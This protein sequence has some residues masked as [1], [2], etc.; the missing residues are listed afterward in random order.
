M[1]KLLLLGTATMAALVLA[2]TVQ[3]QDTPRKCEKPDFRNPLIYSPTEQLPDSRIRFRL[4][5]PEAASPVI[6]SSDIEQ[7]P[8]G[9]D[10]KPAGLPMTLDAFG[11][12]VATTATP[13][14]AGTYAYNIKVAGLT[15]PD[16]QADRFS[17]NYRGVSSVLE[18][19]GADGAFQTFDPAVAHGAVATIDYRSASLGVV[20]RAHVYTPPGYEKGGNRRYP[21]LYLVHGA[22][23]SDDS[24]TSRGRAHY[25]LDNLIAAGKAEPMIVV[26]PAGHTVFKPGTDLMMNQDFGNDLIEDLVPLIDRQYRTQADAGHRAMAGLS[27]GGAHTIAWGLPNADL[28]GPIGIFSMGFYMPGQEERFVALNDA[29]LKG[30]AKATA[31]VYF[32]MGKA[33]FLYPAVAPTRAMMD[34]YGIAYQYRESEGGHVWSNW[35]SYLQEFAQLLFK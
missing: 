17:F 16:P 22:G 23:D 12:W 11:Y 29:G 25:I 21:V 14:L 4:C 27:M 5:A 7:I 31:P 9:F 3:A 15:L 2:T 8:S 18:V 28:F 33:D 13:V 34:R 30:R 20:R 6:V 35:R 24:W 10:G 1:V 19:K 32:A 26:M